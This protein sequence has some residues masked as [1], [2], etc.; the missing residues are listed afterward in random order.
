MKLIPIAKPIRIRI[1]SGNE[2]HSSIESLRSNFSTRDIIPLL[3]DGRLYK[4]LINKGETKMAEIAE[5]MIGFD[6]EVDLTDSSDICRFIACV[7]GEQYTDTLQLVDIFYRLKDIYPRSYLNYVLDFGDFKDISTAVEAYYTYPDL[8]KCK[9]DTIFVKLLKA[10]PLS[11]M[12][13]QFKSHKDE[14]PISDGCWL[15][16]FNH[17]V[18]DA[19]PQDLYK[20]GDTACRNSFLSTQASR[21]IMKSAEMGCKEAI[22]RIG[23]CDCS[24]IDEFIK[25]PSVFRLTHDGNQE[26]D[27][28]RFLCMMSRVYS[29]K[30]RAYEEEIENVGKFAKYLELVNAFWELCR[31]SNR[32]NCIVRLNKM[33][34]KYPNYKAPSEFKT[35]LLSRNEIGNKRLSAMSYESSI[36]FVA[37]NVKLELRNGR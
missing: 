29:Q 11:D 23:K 26:N 34:E 33:I 18:R 37:K 25:S 6:S 24:L 8:K 14:I 28:V 13:L 3:S 17:F 10:M 30:N 7:F 4:W 2:E 35:A 19:Q 9:W 36:I 15:Q 1:V 27:L 5:S 22:E 31:A 21:W 12:V 32:V 16:V 20:L